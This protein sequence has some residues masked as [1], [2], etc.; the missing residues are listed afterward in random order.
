[1]RSHLHLLS[2]AGAALAVAGLAGAV[3]ADDQEGAIKTS[4]SIGVNLTYNFNRPYDRSTG[5]LF[6]SGEGQF[7]LNAAQIQLSRAATEKNAGFRLRLIEGDMRRALLGDSSTYSGE[8][9]T[10]SRS[11]GFSS[12]AGLGGSTTH[13][14]EAYGIARWGEHC[15]WEAGQFESTVGYEHIGDGYG[16]FFSRGIQYQF[17]HPILNLGV[18]LTRHMNEKTSITGSVLNRYRG[19]GDDGNREYQYGLQLRQQLSEE[20]SLKI[21]GQSGRDGMNGTN[22][23]LATINRTISILNG[24]YTNK[25]GENGDL[26]VDASWLGG[27]QSDN[28]SFNV[29]GISGYLTWKVGGNTAGA[30]AEYLSQSNATA[31]VLPQSSGNKKPNLSSI[32][33]SYELNQGVAPGARTLLEYRLDRANT[34]IFAG[35]NSGQAKKDQSTFTV[36]QIFNF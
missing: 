3:F 28:R 23:S 14:L 25:L 30:R 19:A 10:S 16:A 35:R 9:N 8:Y 27:K 7:A 2:A 13:I 20:S 32:T 6:N 26:A 12:S 34:A 5:Y 29:S 4:G 31:G 21:S 17:L 33:L 36:A 18:R 1:M 11:M 22:G 24:V 15:Q